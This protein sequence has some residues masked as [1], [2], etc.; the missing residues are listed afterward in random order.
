MIEHKGTVPLHQVILEGYRRGGTSIANGVRYRVYA[1]MLD[2]GEIPPDTYEQLYEAIVQL[3]A[4]IR[5]ASLPNRHR[6]RLIAHLDCGL[7][8][9]KAQKYAYIMKLFSELT[10]A[11]DATVPAM[12]LSTQ[13]IRSHFDFNPDL[14][15]Q[16]IDDARDKLAPP[17]SL[18]RAASVWA[19]LQLLRDTY[20]QRVQRRDREE[21]S[22]A[23]T[24]AQ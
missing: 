22:R 20:E 8:G 18:P 19:M 6:N 11:P 23:G 3:K 4:E 2:E 24:S 1:E 12:E 13:L 15:Y 10:T 5:V 7:S 14:I 21:R 16:H 17:C 9:I